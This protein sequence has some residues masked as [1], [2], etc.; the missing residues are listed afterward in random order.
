METSHN[1]EIGS[2]SI[3][4]QKNVSKQD[5]HS[6][7]VLYAKACLETQSK[8]PLSSAPSIINYKLT[9]SE[10]TAQR[11]NT[12]LNQTVTGNASTNI[13]A[14]VCEQINN[15]PHCHYLSILI[16]QFKI[17]CLCQVQQRHEFCWGLC[18]L[19]GLLSFPQTSLS[20]PFPKTAAASAHSL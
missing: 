15:Y 2:R 14:R 17:K 18:H 8:D 13:P 9:V 3:S 20:L 12:V 1:Y 19:I 16:N 7:G 11:L 5:N 6:E 4:V 10:N